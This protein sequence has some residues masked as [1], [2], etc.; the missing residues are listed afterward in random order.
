M[1][2][3]LKLFFNTEY[4]M[5]R[6][7]DERYFLVNPETVIH[8]NEPVESQNLIHNNSNSSKAQINEMDEKVELHFHGLDIA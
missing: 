2:N 7:N 6:D 5:R 4:D 3:L 8:F 1:V